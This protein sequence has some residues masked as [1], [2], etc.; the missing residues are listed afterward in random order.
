M[1]DNATV[2]PTASDGSSGSIETVVVAGAGGAVVFSPPQA[3]RLMARTKYG[4]DLC[5]ATL[6][7]G[8]TVNGKPESCRQS[9][10]RARA[11]LPLVYIR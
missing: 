7:S 5:N 10:E 3:A 8:P 6:R 4:A 1:A 11:Q 2:A 9:E